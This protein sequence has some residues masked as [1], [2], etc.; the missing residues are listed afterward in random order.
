[1]RSAL[2]PI[3]ATLALASAGCGGGGEDDYENRLRPPTPINVTAAI[4]E[5]RVS[6]SPETFGAGPI[7]LLVS[8]QSGK[9]QAIT[10]ET[11]EIGG[12]SP[13]LRKAS[14]P[15]LAGGTGSMQV[16]VREGSYAVS[17]D[18]PGIEPAT[19]EVSGKRASAQ[20][21]LLQP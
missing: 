14:R 16:D 3:A 6:V 20:D 17:V 19:V 8:N 9:E 21:Q 7:V 2:L 11:E 12:E 1:V 13:G 15:I 5:E 10:F 4:T 18:D